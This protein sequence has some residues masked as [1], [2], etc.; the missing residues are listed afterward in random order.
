MNVAAPG[1]SG[2]K[3]VDDLGT[4]AVGVRRATAILRPAFAS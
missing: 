1:L 4:H 3:R 2:E